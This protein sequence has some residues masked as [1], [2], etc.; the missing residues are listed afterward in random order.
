M[1]LTPS[2]SWT[3]HPKQAFYP[4]NPT[5]EQ[6][7]DI[8]KKDLDSLESQ[9]QL[10]ELLNTKIQTATRKHRYILLRRNSRRL[11]S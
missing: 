8:A 5:A 1:K 11:S 9:M 6:T 7:P 10:L 3:K 4:E 2:T